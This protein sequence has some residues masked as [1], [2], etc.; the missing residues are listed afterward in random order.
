M[1]SIEEK[2]AHFNEL[3]LREAASQRDRILKELKEEEGYQ[4]EARK[5]EFEAQAS[6]LLRRESRAIEKEKNN[7]ISGSLAEGKLRLMKTREL[8]IETLFSELKEKL[9][10][11]T[12]TPEYRDFLKDNVS[13]ACLRAGEGELAVFV[14]ERDLARHGPELR[15]ILKNNGQSP[16]LEA[17]EDAV[18]GGCRVLNKTCHIFI[19]DTLLKRMELARDEFFEACGLRVD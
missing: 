4:L 14:T 13:N 15:G 12:E 17:I 7:I 9:R 8:L 3:I 1:S 10:L 18:I 5:K 6:E 16:A 19:D 2:L 11:F